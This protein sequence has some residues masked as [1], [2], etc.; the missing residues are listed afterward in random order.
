MPYINQPD[1]LITY[2][3]KVVETNPFVAGCAIAMRENFYKDHRY[4]MAYFHR[5]DNG[6][7]DYSD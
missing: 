6:S 4:F 2:S 3:R 7:L 1:S 5:N